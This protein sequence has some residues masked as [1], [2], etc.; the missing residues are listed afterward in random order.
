MQSLQKMLKDYYSGTVPDVLITRKIWG[1]C[2]AIN[3]QGATRVSVTQLVRQEEST[4]IRFCKK[5]GCDL[6]LFRLRLQRSL[7]TLYMDLYE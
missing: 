5:T 7:P 4:W 2:K 1:I 6:Q 3:A